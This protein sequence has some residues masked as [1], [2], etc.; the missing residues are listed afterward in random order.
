[1]QTSLPQGGVLALGNFDGVHCGHRAVLEKGKA[2]TLS[3]GV[4]FYALTFQPHPLSYFNKKAESFLLTPAPLKE[5]LLKEAGVDAVIALP[6]DNIL[7][8]KTPQAFVQE[9][10]IDAL[11]AR[12]VVVGFNFAFG[13]DRAGDHALLSQTLAASRIGFDP[14]P[15][16]RD[17]Q[18]HIVSSSR[19]RELIK[20][21]DFD[22]ARALLG[23]PFIVSGRVE[24][25]KSLGHQLSYPTA[26]IDPQDS[27]RPPVGA[28]IMQARTP[29][30]LWHQAMG[31]YGPP[32]DVVEVHLFDFHKDLYGQ[33]L[34]VAFLAPLRPAQKFDSTDQLKAQLAKDAQKARV[35]FS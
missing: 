16:C 24:K 13:C 7:A 26:N 22:Q 28:Y 23:R 15:A 1:M 9:I 35:Y 27:I 11:A 20:S 5:C 14:V 2:L 10:L 32:K 25:G 29:D 18:G 19:L 12:H 21:G 30:G 34:D 33:T 17:A 3:Y 8:S 4:P 6:F 31:Y